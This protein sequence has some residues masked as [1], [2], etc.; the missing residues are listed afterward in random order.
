MNT[1][2]DCRTKRYYLK[3][4]AIMIYHENGV[5]VCDSVSSFTMRKTVTTA[6]VKTTEQFCTSK[7]TVAAF[8]LPVLSQLV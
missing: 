3:A 6:Q 8:S 1:N 7:A 5:D 2:D 4:D